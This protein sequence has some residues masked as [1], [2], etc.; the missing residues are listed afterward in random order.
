MSSQQKYSSY[1]FSFLISFSILP[2][3]VDDDLIKN[4]QY[5]TIVNN[6][7]KAIRVYETF[8]KIRGRGRI[9]R[10]KNFGWTIITRMNKEERQYVIDRVKAIERGNDEKEEQLKIK[11]NTLRLRKERRLLLENAKVYQKYPNRTRRKKNYNPNTQTMENINEKEIKI[12]ELYTPKIMY[13]YKE[14]TEEKEKQQGIENTR[15]YRNCKIEIGKNR[16]NNELKQQNDERIITI[17][18]EEL[19]NVGRLLQ[20]NQ[21]KSKKYS[22]LRGKW[23]ENI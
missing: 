13:E 11:M 5:R 21:N 4:Y 1:V 14:M 8:N 9:I 6:T 12:M 10:I 3:D 15:E 16:F 22:K 19:T 2:S 17:S 7:A 23:L 18:I 20:N